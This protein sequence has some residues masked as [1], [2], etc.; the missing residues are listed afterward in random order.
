VRYIQT[1]G[2]DSAVGIVADSNGDVYVTG[3][4]SASLTLGSTTLTNRGGQDVF[5]VKLDG[6]TGSPVWAR[7]LGGTT[8]DAG[9]GVAV[10]NVLGS[11]FVAGSVSSTWSAGSFNYTSFGSTDA[12]I[13]QLDTSSGNFTSAIRIGGTAADVAQ[14]IDVNDL[15]EPVA[16]GYTASATMTIGYSAGRTNIGS[17]DFWIAGRSLPLVSELM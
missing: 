3:F 5:I 16:A 4:Y 13:A 15:G 7:S 8:S 1:S 12:F 6:S 11:L 2:S 9:N 10:D 17:N 14:G